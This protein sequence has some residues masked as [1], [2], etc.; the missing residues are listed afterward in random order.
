MELNILEEIIKYKEFFGRNIDQMPNL[1][2]EGRVPMNTSQLMKK[3]LEV[4][5]GEVPREKKS[6]WCSRGFNTFDVV[7]YN[8]NRDIKIVLDYQPLKEINP[9]SQINYGG[10]TISED[11]Y[12][13]LEGEILNRDN[14]GNNIPLT[15]EEAKK[16]PVWRVLARDQDLLNDYVDFV[17]SER[18]DKFFYD[19]GMSVFLNYSPSQKLPELR[20]WTISSIEFGSDALGIGAIDSGLGRFIGI[21][22]EKSKTYNNSKL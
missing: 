8:L 10:L 20:L 4:L 2:A 22:E 21:L 19:T 1:I 6:F 17:F 7:I 13:A 16:N 14:I 15:K 11:F 12:K 9:K 18:K 3:R 5:S